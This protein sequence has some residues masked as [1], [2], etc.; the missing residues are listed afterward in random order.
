MVRSLCVTAL[1]VR[2]RMEKSIIVPRK[3][4][5]TASTALNKPTMNT[6]TTSPVKRKLPLTNEPSPTKKAKLDGN[7]TTTTTVV[8]ASPEPVTPIPGAGAGGGPDQKE[9]Q[10]SA[11]K[12]TL[13]HSQGVSLFAAPPSA[14]QPLMPAHVLEAFAQIQREQAASRTRGMS[15]FRG[16]GVGR[17]RVALV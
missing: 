1:E 2:D 12:P 16:G 8:V 13:L 9:V 17:G 3:S 14:R 11:R 4:A 15:N 5:T 10:G 6:L 7:G